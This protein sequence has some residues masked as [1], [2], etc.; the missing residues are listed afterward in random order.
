MRVGFDCGILQTNRSGT[1]VS[2]RELFTA[3]QRMNAEGTYVAL[4]PPLRLPRHNPAT[5]VGNLLLDLWYLHVWIPW[6]VIQANLDL[7]H[8]PAN[9]ASLA[10]TCP[11][12]VTI[13]DVSFLRYPVAHD[14]LWL[15]YARFFVHQSARRADQIITVSKTAKREIMRAYGIPSRRVK[16]IYN[17]VSSGFRQLDQQEARAFVC[18]K[19]GLDPTPFVLS[20]GDLMPRKNLDRLIQAFAVFRGTETGQSHQLLIVGGEERYAYK[21]RLMRLIDRLELSS[22]VHLVGYV[23]DREVPFFLNAAGLFV[24][25]S[26]EEGFGLPPLEA[27]ACGVP[28][29]SSAVSAMSEVLNDAAFLVPPTEVE[30]IAQAMV[31][32]TR[33][34]DLRRELVVRGLRRASIFTWERAAIETMTLYRHVVSRG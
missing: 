10:T 21:R 32:V 1:M 20:I 29:V 28:V 15:A 33:D 34:Q 23:P 25:V 2:T 19:Y 7:V 6:R 8:Y 4:H 30:A 31:S 11:R 26:L 14:P 3:L 13:H 9:I 17:G 24:F 5:K 18:A 12:I 16:V 27:M 22:V